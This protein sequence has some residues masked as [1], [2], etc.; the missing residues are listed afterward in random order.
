MATITVAVLKANG[1]SIKLTK[2]YQPIGVI[3]KITIDWAVRINCLQALGFYSY[4]CY[5]QQA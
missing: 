2:P 1:F 3:D 4:E 5:N